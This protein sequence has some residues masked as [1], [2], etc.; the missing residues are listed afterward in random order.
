MRLWSVW[1]C[2]SGVGL[3]MG[4]LMIGGCGEDEGGQSPTPMESPTAAPTVTPLTLCVDAPVVTWANFLE[5]FMVE[6][7]Q[8]CHASAATERYGAPENVTFDTEGQVETWETRILARATGE[9]PSM[10]PGGGVSADDRTLLGISLVC[11]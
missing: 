9:S 11:W 3:M 1:G 2:L 7:C 8:T 4:G 6:N 5:G 10:P